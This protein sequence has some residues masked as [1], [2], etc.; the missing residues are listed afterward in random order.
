MDY[1]LMLI[2]RGVAGAPAVLL[3]TSPADGLGPKL[4]GLLAGFPAISQRAWR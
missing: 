2:I 3:V 1:S 4:G